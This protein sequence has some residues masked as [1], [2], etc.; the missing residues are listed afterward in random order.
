MLTLAITVLTLSQAFCRVLVQL[1]TNASETSISIVR[2]NVANDI[3]LDYGHWGR[4]R[5]VGL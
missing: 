4:Q 1:K 3:Q 2:A 5:K